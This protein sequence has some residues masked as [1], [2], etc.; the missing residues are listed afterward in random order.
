MW[1]DSFLSFG[2]YISERLKKVKII[3]TRIKG[4]N[5]TYGLFPALVQKIQIAVINLVALYG[6]K[7]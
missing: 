6:A 7:L 1:F 5:K 4:L 3:K 2:A